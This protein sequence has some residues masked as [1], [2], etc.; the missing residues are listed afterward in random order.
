MT[1]KGIRLSYN[2]I[3][4]DGLTHLRDTEPLS[5]IPWCWVTGTGKKELTLEKHPENLW[6]REFVYGT[7]TTR[8]V[9]TQDI[10]EKEPTVFTIVL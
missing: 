4:Q 6:L 8:S 3:Y 7:V 9:S 5:R 10:S 1:N 2:P